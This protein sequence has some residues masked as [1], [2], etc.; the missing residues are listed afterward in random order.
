MVTGSFAQ[1]G[2]R[3]RVIDVCGRLSQQQSSGR[4][5]GEGMTIERGDDGKTTR[6]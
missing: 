2:Y 1:Q 4:A 6:E 5:S 3:L